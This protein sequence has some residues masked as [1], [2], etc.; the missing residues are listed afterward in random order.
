[1][2]FTELD[3]SLVAINLPARTRDEVIDQLLGMLDRTGKVRD[4]DLARTDIERSEQLMAFGMQHGIAIPHAKTEA[5]EELL[6]CFAV[7]ENPVDFSGIDGTP[8]RIFIMTL[9]PPDQIGPHIRFLSEIGRL[10]KNRKVRKAILGA[11][12]PEQLLRIIKGR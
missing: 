4:L 2:L 10:L 1:M 12:T 3:E 5:V 11:E 6:A 9:S 8:S 7:T